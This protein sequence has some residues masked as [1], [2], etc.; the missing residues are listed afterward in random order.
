MKLEF[1]RQIFE[2]HAYTKFQENSFSG[3]LIV[4]CRRTDGQT[5]THDEVNSRLSQFCGCAYKSRN[6]KSTILN[7][8][9]KYQQFLKHKMLYKIEE[10]S[11]C[12]KPGSTQTDLMKDGAKLS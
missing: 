7:F 10:E 11:H 3:G 9:L 8:L 2:K 12:R 1:S 4:P 6:M 5:E